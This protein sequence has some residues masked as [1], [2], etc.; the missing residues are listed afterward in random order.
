M[1]EVTL[2]YDRDKALKIALGLRGTAL[3]IAEVM[4]FDPIPAGEPWESMGLR[5]RQLIWLAEQFEAAARQM[6]PELPAHERPKER[7][8]KMVWCQGEGCERAMTREQAKA[9]GLCPVC[10]EKSAAK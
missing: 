3:L 9:S 7:N 2:S 10:Q 6:A 1:P 4:R 8:R 5:C